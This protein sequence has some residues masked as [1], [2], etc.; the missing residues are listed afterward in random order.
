MNV[1]Q[2]WRL[3]AERAAW[4]LDQP[5]IWTLAMWLVPVFFGLVSV[6]MRQDSNWDLRNYHFYNPFAWL[7][8]KVGLDLAPAQMQSY[9]NPTIDLLYYGLAKV[10]PVRVIGFVMGTIHGLNFVLVSN[11]AVEMLST[12]SHAR[13]VRLPLFLAFAGMLSAGFISQ[14]G[15]TMGDNLTALFVLGALLMVLR[16]WGTFATG[17]SSPCGGG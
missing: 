12:G 7:N 16:H 9:F 13:R 14:L 5:H 10:A 4:R 6:S 2:R 8:G 1:V 11:I 15:N 17:R 3:K